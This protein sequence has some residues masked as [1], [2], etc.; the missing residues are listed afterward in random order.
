MD[1]GVAMREEILADKLAEG[2][3]GRRL[4]TWNTC[5]VP[6][7]LTPGLDESA[8]RGVRRLVARLLPAGGRRALEPEGRGGALCAHLRPSPLDADRGRAVAAIPRMAVPRVTAPE[9]DSSSDEP[10]D[11]ADEDGSILP[12][13]S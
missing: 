7:R 11:P 6:T 5:R 3:A 12:R 4:A 10:F 13:T 8:V 2:R 1:L 9:R